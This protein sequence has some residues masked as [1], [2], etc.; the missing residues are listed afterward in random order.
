MNKHFHMIAGAFALAAVCAA[1]ATNPHAN[2]SAQRLP[3]KTSAS[4]P[5]T[6]RHKTNL[7]L[8]ATVS[9]EE[10]EQ[11]KQTIADQQKEEQQRF[12]TLQLQNQQLG[13]ELKA[14]REKLSAAEE[15][16]NRLSTEEDPQIV[17][18]QSAVAA[19]KS[20]Q[21]AT[22]A[23][24]EHVKKTLPESQNP[25]ALRYKGVSITPGGYFAGS[26]L[27]RSHAEN[28]D[29]NT[30]WSS[31]PLNS[32]VMAHLSEFRASARQ[33]LLSLRAEGKA[34]NSTLTGYFETDFLGAGSG[35]SEVQSDG[36]S[37]RIRQLWGRVQFPNRWTFA[38]GQ[39]WSLLTTNR[40]GIENLTEF[41]TPLIDSSQFIGNDYAR[42]T[43]FRITKSFL[44]GNKLTAAFA[45]ENAATVGVTPTN[46]PS[47]VTNTLSGLSTTGTGAL[48]NTTYSTNVAP[49]LIA[50]VAFDPKYGHFEI[51]AIGR[52]FRDRIDSTTS[53]TTPVVT[54]PGHN[55][56]LLGGGMGAAV[57]VPV[58]TKKINYIAQGTWGEIG[59]YGATSTDVVVKP[60]GELSGEKSVHMLTGIETHPTGKFD[61][62]AFASDEYLPRNNGYGLKTINN[63][64]CFIE[65]T[66]GSSTA[67][68][69][70]PSTRNLEGGTT[71]VWYRP[72][73]G[74]AGTV[75]YGAGY[76]YV[77]KNTWMGTG[78]APRGIENIVET[79][80]RYILP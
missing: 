42:Q 30:T 70:S 52:V 60:N 10:L 19:V 41:S 17:K 12:D 26:T 58:F 5:T 65:A 33:T 4:A 55:N 68:S 71:G 69:C 16:I 3:K 32:Q 39:M 59:R 78:G 76:I 63:A 66:A 11:V 36:Y 51:K 64:G 73:K 79:S 25:L 45:A 53:T 56:T 43:A 22:T 37:N 34:G 38:A 24:V 75:Q 8:S 6:Q 61:W 44:Q 7:A 9:K 20:E 57:V 14:T 15:R 47:S 62:Y 49:D 13:L 2:P 72:Y 1:Q 27:Y 21:V 35:A 80:F 31:I 28:A 74:T 23:Y 77:V 50:K 48:S 40:T 29:I 54:T 18:L 46:V 67:P